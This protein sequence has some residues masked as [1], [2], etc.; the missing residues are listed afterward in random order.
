MVNEKSSCKD[1]EMKTTNMKLPLPLLW[2]LL[3]TPLVTTRAA[4]MAKPTA[5]AG[6]VFYIAPTGPTPLLVLWNR[7]R[8]ASTSCVW[9]SAQRRGEPSGSP[10]NART[11]AGLNE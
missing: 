9:W 7:W 6:T 2:A 10:M 11:K 8:T 5:A 4:D 3:L 1:R